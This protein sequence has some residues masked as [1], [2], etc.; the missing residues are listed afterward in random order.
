M[1]EE[2]DIYL[3]GRFLSVWDESG[4]LENRYVSDREASFSIYPEE[5]AM[6]AQSRS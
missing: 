6:S 2:N 3:S 4:S 5:V 1:L